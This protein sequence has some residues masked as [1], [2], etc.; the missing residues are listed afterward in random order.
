MSRGLSAD[1]CSGKKSRH[2]RGGNRRPIF[3]GSDEGWAMAKTFGAQE[4]R[5]CFKTSA[6]LKGKRIGPGCVFEKGGGSGEMH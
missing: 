3:W 6:M 1:R 4:E 5:G 2:S